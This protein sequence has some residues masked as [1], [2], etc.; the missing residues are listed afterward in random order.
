MKKTYLNA[1]ISIFCWSTVATVCKILL[2]DLN[3]M[4]LLW[5]NSLIAG[6][7]LFIINL[8]TGNFKIYSYKLK[9]YLAMMLIGIPG[10]FFY[11]IFYY[12]GTDILPASQAFIINYLWPIMSVLFACLILGEKLTVKKII[13]IIISF[14]GVVVVVG[15]ALKDLNINAIMGALFC[16]LGAVSYGLFTA[17][18]QK[19]N[20]NKSMTLMVSYLTTLVLTT[21]INGVKGDL[22]LPATSQVAGFLWN[23]IFAVAIA[24][25]CWVNALKSGDTA[26]VSN[27][28]YITPFVSG[29]WTYIFLNEKITASSV[30]GLG[31]IILG[32]F[33]QL[34]DKKKA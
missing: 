25:T 1:A 29:I 21:I 28:A 12:S 4:Q 17:L 20:Y 26:K 2:A 9:D 11:Y 31:I 3:S 10:T 5:M 13:A 6:V 15:D 33:I 8:A 7:F 27:L 18:N 14:L 32:I 34:K 30:V 22:F 16:I 24:N 19:K 23:G